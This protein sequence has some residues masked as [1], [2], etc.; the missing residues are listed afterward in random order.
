MQMFVGP[1][2]HPLFGGEATDA[3]PQ[4]LDGD[5]DSGVIAHEFAHVRVQPSSPAA[6]SH[7]P[8]DL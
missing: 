7:V 3:T 8:A 6:A 2:D 4:L 5:F 1:G